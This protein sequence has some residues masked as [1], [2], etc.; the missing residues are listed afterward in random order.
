MDYEISRELDKKLALP[1]RVILIASL[2]MPL[3]MFLPLIS[4]TGGYNV[5]LWKLTRLIYELFKH[6]GDGAFVGIVY[7]GLFVLT[8]IF[9]LFAAMYGYQQKPAVVLVF[10]LLAFGSFYILT[11]KRNAV[12]SALYGWGFGYYLFVFAAIAVAAGAVWMIVKKNEVLTQAKIAAVQEMAAVGVAESQGE[13]RRPFV[14]KGIP[15]TWVCS[16]GYRNDI[17]KTNCVKCNRVRK[18]EY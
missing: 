16:C 14:Y 9:A 17:D 7:M 11:G 4:A 12:I 2:L 1:F 3:S 15:E 8:I 10:D 18:Q 5:S 6:S 13:N